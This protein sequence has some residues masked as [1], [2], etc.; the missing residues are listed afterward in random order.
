MRSLV[1]LAKVEYLS[2]AVHL[3]ELGNSD[4]WSLL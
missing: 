2:R 4:E 1:Y 3:A